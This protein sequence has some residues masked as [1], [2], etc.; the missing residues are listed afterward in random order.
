[1]PSTGLKADKTDKTANMFFARGRLGAGAG[2]GSGLAGT[3]N[4]NCDNDDRIDILGAYQN[5]DSVWEL[6]LLGGGHVANAA[7]GHHSGV[8]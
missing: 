1:M 5:R 3:A 7:V 4:A 8:K 2:A 6:G